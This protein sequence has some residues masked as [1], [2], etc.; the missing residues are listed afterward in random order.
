[1][2]ADNGWI[3]GAR[4]ERSEPSM[5]LLPAA[6]WSLIMAGYGARE[7]SGASRA[8]A[9]CLLPDSGCDGQKKPNFMFYNI[10]LTI[11]VLIIVIDIILLRQIFVYVLEIY[12][13]CSDFLTYN[14][15]RYG[16]K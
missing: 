7:A 5:G 10:L 16:K 11:I 3:W 1:M 6:A 15:K 13:L 12:Y 4:G 2:V 8:S 9:C 14:I